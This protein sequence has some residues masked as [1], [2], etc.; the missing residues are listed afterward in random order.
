MIWMDYYLSDA[1][2]KKKIGNGRSENENE[3]M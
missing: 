3:K 1:T 2:N